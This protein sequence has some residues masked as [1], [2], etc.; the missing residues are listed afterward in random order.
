MSKTLPIDAHPRFMLVAGI[1]I[2]RW[3]GLGPILARGAD[4][5]SLTS[6]HG[7]I[8]LDFVD[9][10]NGRG[11]IKGAVVPSAGWGLT[12]IDDKVQVTHTAA[13]TVSAN[14]AWGFTSNTAAVDVS[15]TF[16]ATAQADWARG[17]I[18]TH[19]VVT[20]G[21][22]AA[23]NVPDFDGGNA[24]TPFRAASLVELL[25]EVGT[26]GDADDAH[27]ADNLQEL[28][29]V[30]LFADGWCA[31]GLN[32]E[33]RVFFAYPSG[34]DDITFPDTVVGNSFRQALGFTSNAPTATTVNGYRL[35]V[36]DEPSEY[37]FS[38]ERP[39]DYCRRV[40]ID[41]AAVTEDDGGQLSSI[42]FG[43]AF[44]WMCRVYVGGPASRVNE[45]SH[46][47]RRFLRRVRPGYPVTLYR[48]T[49][50]PR[51]A[52]EPP[53]GEYS[54]L[55]TPEFY[56]ERGRIRGFW[57]ADN[58]RE[59]M[60]SYDQGVRLRFPLDFTISERSD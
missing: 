12:L 33:G 48:A 38:P 20:P 7:P 44:R 6:D 26:I 10:L 56:G 31:S 39:I 55:E 8:Y 2:S 53:F 21:G 42:H 46:L 15:G 54:L 34:G 47:L 59:V 50:E 40:S 19:L 29:S 5:L 11:S 51:R 60:A 22:G 18:D 4:T 52:V 43:E 9:F 45:E 13:F 28:M 41:N 36:A 1:N 30:A 58:R 16:T 3:Q 14:V 25:R 57:H 27:P 23:F 24:G 35:M 49:T 17:A 37:V 32:D